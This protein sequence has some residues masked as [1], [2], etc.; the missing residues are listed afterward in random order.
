MDNLRRFPAPW[1]MEECKDG[2]RVVDA[3][4]F[5]ICGVADHLYS[6]RAFPNFDS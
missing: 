4:G 6:A 3:S 1:A 5:I 2:F